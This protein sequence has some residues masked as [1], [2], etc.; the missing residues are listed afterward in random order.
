[1]SIDLVV[2]GAIIKDH[3]MIHKVI[4]SVLHYDDLFRKKYI[5]LDGT[6]DDKFIGFIENY[7]W[8]KKDI[9]EKYEDYF[10]IIQFD[11]N[12]YFRE[13]IH[14]ICKTSDAKY[15]FVI[16]D[17]AVVD[18]MNLGKILIDMSIKDMKLLS[19][20]HKQ[21]P[22]DNSHHWF[23]GFGDMFPDPYI[24]THGWSE[25]VF[26]CDRM[27]FMNALNNS[28]K[29]SKNTINFCDTIYHNKMKSK[30]WENM[31]DEDKEEYW[32]IWG[33]Y[34]HWNVFHRHLVAKR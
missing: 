11:K 31:T 4:D 12:I 28:S 13:M 3:N 20:P 24:K 18:N 16:Q 25:R 21:I 2:C 33:P 26:I 19:F 1:M 30:E 27:H 9:K 29:N 17:D 5:L 7:N 34:T 23:E 32:K 15:L 8:Y 14:H 10:D 22:L 6:P